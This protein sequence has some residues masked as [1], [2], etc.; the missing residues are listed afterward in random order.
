MKDK[1]IL[2]AKL[3]EFS[4]RYHF[5]RRGECLI[6][7]LLLSLVGYLVVLLFD[8]FVSLPPGWPLIFLAL[9]GLS[10]A[11]YLV[12]NRQR[13]IS[14]FELASQIDEKLKLEERIS[15][16]WEYQNR[17]R[18]KEI[19]QLLTRDALCHL[20]KVRVSQVFPCYWFKRGKYAIYLLTAILLV[21]FSGYFFP[22]SSKS[23]IDSPDLFQEEGQLLMNVAQKLIKKGRSESLERASL[24]AL[25]MRELGKDIYYK[26]LKEDQAFSAYHQLDKEIVAA[27]EK[28]RNSLLEKLKRLREEGK[29]LA[30]GEFSKLMKALEKG[31]YQRVNNL[32]QGHS[33]QEKFD[34]TK[35]LQALEMMRKTLRRSYKQAKEKS[36]KK[37]SDEKLA[38]AVSNKEMGLPNREDGKDEGHSLVKEKE[39]N[40]LSDSGPGEGSLPGNTSSDDK[41]EKRVES[42]EK[43]KLNRIEGQ[44]DQGSFL[45][46]LLKG[47]SDSSHKPGFSTE[48]A[49]FSYKKEMMNRLAE[50]RIPL[51]Y[52][53][54]IKKY[55]SSLEPE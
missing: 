37:K 17:K 19:I 38:E 25:Q 22:F 28:S 26:N 29:T 40:F 41:K 39:R 4:R 52:K 6:N 18:P 3:E 2:T 48:K 31:D 27:L 51:S 23:K 5:L 44:F 49:F 46:S 33:L 36:G 11:I 35:D 42:E 20:Q 55:F 43:G 54:Q 15:T 10:I 32:L 53:E 16:A 34:E 47:I 12:L 1:Q 14:F 30:Q 13:R 8:K 9:C 24:L 21:S 7:W 50:E 45:M